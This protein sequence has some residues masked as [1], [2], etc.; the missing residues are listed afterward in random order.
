MGG[1]SWSSNVYSST[2]RSKIDSGTSFLYSDDTRSKRRSEWKAHES[3][4]PLSV[5]GPAS[6]FAGRNIRE[7]RDSIEHPNSTPIAVF[8]DETGSM[9]YVPVELQKD[10]TK[11]FDLLVNQGM[12]TD[13]QVM[14]GAYGDAEVDQVPLQAGQF[15]SDNRVDDALDNL[16]LEGNGG[17]NR[18]EHSALA[19]YYVATHTDTDNWNKRGKRGYLF[20]IG[21]EISGTIPR[22]AIKQFCGDDVQSDIT[23]K[24][25]LA[26]ANEKWNVFH[27]V[28]DNYT[29]REQR[30]VKFYT[31]LLKGNCIV[32]E[33]VGQIAEM[34][35]A[36]V[37][38][39]EGNLKDN[40]VSKVVVDQ[41]HVIGEAPRPALTSV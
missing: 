15:E 9:G 1:G 4:D 14:I 35:A 5:A 38:L 23:P 40:S 19:W 28:V 21:D 13:P 16:F 22:E 10:L 7:S 39:F 32:V 33:D 36:V 8:F 34:I 11:L 20:T 37:G 18:H 12:A 27:I 24:Q 17:G 41:V 3:V 2:T 25:A 26:M 6:P 30:S 29:A 31:D